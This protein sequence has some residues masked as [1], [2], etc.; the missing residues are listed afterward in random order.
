MAEKIHWALTVQ[1][2][3]GPKISA[4]KTINHVDAYDKIDVVINAGEEE[5][6]QVQPGDPG[7][8]QFLLI[9]SDRYAPPEQETPGL[10]YKVNGTGKAIE[11]DALQLLMG[12]GAVGLLGAGP[13][14][15]VFSNELDQ[16]ASIEILVGR[17]ATKDK[18]DTTP[19]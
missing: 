9:R 6:V 12:D 11:L 10:S 16:D 4:S 15:L 13:K 3:G 7:Q 18:E 1:V 14:T 8:V 19:P 5:E 2:V 17:K